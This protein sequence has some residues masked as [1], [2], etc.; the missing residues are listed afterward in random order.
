[1]DTLETLREY[2]TARFARDRSAPLAPDED[3]MRAGV[4]DSMAIMEIV[5][6]LETSWGVSVEGDEVTVDNFQTLSAISALVERKLDG[7]R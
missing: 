6:F 1:M 3:L 5:G 2:V 4:L 7:G